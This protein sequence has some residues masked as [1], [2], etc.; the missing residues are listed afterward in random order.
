MWTLTNSG[1]LKCK[2]SSIETNVNNK[3]T[4]WDW[5]EIN[6]LWVVY[7]AYWDYYNEYYC[8]DEHYSQQNMLWDITIDK[9][10][11]PRSWW[12]PQQW[13]AGLSVC[14]NRWSSS[15]IDPN[16]LVSKQISDSNSCYHNYTTYYTTEW[17]KSCSDTDWN[18]EYSFRWSD[19]IA[20]LNDVDNRKWCG[21]ITLNQWWNCVC[22]F[23]LDQRWNTTINLQWWIQSDWDFISCL[24]W[25]SCHQVWIRWD[26]WDS[27]CR[28]CYTMTWYWFVNWSVYS[29]NYRDACLFIN[30]YRLLYWSTSDTWTKS[31]S[32]LKLKPWDSVCVYSSYSWSSSSYKATASATICDYY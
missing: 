24:S 16:V 1:N 18:K 26:N 29:T 21:T 17:I 5:Q 23:N 12:A 7:W 27:W 4:K 8:Q 9:D 10:I 22:S 14:Q 13:S 6:P 30:W 19:R 31:I 28:W 11:T 15:C 3:L 2:I 32:N 20:T 25:K